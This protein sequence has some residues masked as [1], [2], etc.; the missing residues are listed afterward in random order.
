MLY[1]NDAGVIYLCRFPVANMDSESAVGVKADLVAPLLAPKCT[2]VK[3]TEATSGS[4]PLAID[5]ANWEDSQPLS[6][7]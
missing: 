2:P 6:R 4:V 5:V 7:N 1:P 3:P